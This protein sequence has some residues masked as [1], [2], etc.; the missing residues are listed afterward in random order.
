[1]LSELNTLIPKLAEQVPLEL[2]AFAGSVIEEVLAPIPSPVILTTTGA[3]AAAQSRSW[4]GLIFLVALGAVGKTLGA[5]VLYWAADKLEDALI[6]RFGKY[7]GLTHAHVEAFGAKLGKGWKDE[8]V[9]L[10]AR[11]LPIIPSAPIS[12]ACGLIKLPLRSY[13]WTTFVGTLIRNFLFA[14]VGYLG[15]SQA[16][17]WLEGTQN[18]ESVVQIALLLAA[19]AL[20]VWAYVKRYR[21][22]HD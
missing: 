14:L 10:L 13:L 15:S 2:F 12:I 20:I 8:F 17:T 21:N 5:W 7:L 18:I 3:L 22:K 9:L 11:S 1:M 16:L 19:S 4:L 6:P